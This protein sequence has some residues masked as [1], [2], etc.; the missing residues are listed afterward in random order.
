M[1][2]SLS[3]GSNPDWG[4]EKMKQCLS[5]TWCKD[6]IGSV[7]WST[8]V[9][10]GAF[11]YLFLSCSYNYFKSIHSG[12]KNYDLQLCSQNKAWCTWYITQG[13]YSVWDDILLYLGFLSYCW[14]ISVKPAISPTWQESLGIS[15]LTISGV[16]YLVL[17]C[18]YSACMG[19]W[20]YKI[21]HCISLWHS[22]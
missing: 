15:I 2:Q 11:L 12:V 21:I 10:Q 8:V 19:L 14:I 3:L 5:L 4:I 7:E 13:K 18:F 6:K 17:G 1:W 16:S 9:I 20:S 22:R